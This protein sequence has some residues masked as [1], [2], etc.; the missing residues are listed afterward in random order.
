MALL[1]DHQLQRQFGTACA[2]TR[3]VREKMAGSAAV[4]EDRRVGAS[5]C[6]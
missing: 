1:L 5:I 6:E 3:P 2:V 4:L